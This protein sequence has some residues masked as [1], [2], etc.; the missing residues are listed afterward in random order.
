VRAHLVEGA[1]LDADATALL[2][3]L[4]ARAVAEGIDEETGRELL[5][6]LRARGIRRELAT[7]SPERKIEL[8][9][10]LL[11]LREATTGVS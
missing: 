5:L 10:A 3:E 6:N 1:A 2:A 9:R 8:E 7:A 11:R 4:D